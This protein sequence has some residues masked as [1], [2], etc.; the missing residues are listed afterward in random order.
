MK[1]SSL[2]RIFLFSRLLPQ[3][4]LLQMNTTTKPLD[5]ANLDRFVLQIK[6]RGISYGRKWDEAKKVIEL[7]ADKPLDEKIPVRVSKEI[8]DENYKKLEEVVIPQEVQN[9]LADFI[10]ILIEDYGL[11]EG[12][13]LISDR[14]FFVKSLK[15]LK[16]H[17]L[18]NNREVCTTEDLRAL[19]YMTAFRIPEE[20]YNQIDEILD[21][22]EGKKKNPDDQLDDQER[23]EAESQIPEFDENM[24]NEE[25]RGEVPDEEAEQETENELSEARKTFFQALKELKENID[26]EEDDNEMEPPEGQDIPSEPTGKPKDSGNADRED[27]S[28]QAFMGSKS[29]K[30]GEDDETVIPGKRN[31]ETAENIKT[32]MRVLEGDFQR[33]IAKK[34]FHPGGSPRKWKTMTSFDELEDIDPLEAFL[35]SQDTGPNLPHVQLREK[36]V[37][38]GEI[39]ILRDVSTSMMGV[40]S[41]WSSSVVKGVIELAR[42]KRMRVGY[43]EFNHKSFKY[44]KK[45]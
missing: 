29:E 44:K 27:K 8:F 9:G 38:G 4:T 30:A 37:M 34:S 25:T 19:K 14:T 5:P 28:S 45:L 10:T 6:S 15:I 42:T 16:S 1:E 11:N 35:W 24:E 13:S 12:N 20:V 31:Y 21:S 36:E 43:V 40:Y 22:I 7:Y 32:I 2:M 23:R 17:A 3:V 39:A 18:L 33:N 41:E 26:G